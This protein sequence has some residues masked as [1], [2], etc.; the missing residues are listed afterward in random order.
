M[1][2]PDYNFHRG[3]VLIFSSGEYSDY[4]IVG[5]LV[6]VRDLKLK[7]LVKQFKSEFIAKD[8]WDRASPDNFPSWLVSKELAMPIDST[9]VYLGDY[10]DFEGSLLDD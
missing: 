2:K 6:A 4:H 9:E 3:S 1:T 5:F 10:S 8:K 7:E